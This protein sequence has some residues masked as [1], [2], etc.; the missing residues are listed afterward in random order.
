MR[1]KLFAVASLLI[2]ASMLLAA[3]AQPQT[4]PPP[5]AT[6][7]TIIQTQI[8]E[9]TVVVTVEGKTT[10]VTATPQPDLW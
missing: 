6:P 8:I 10:I 7:E 4:P 1:N 9:K 5:A 2:V 3:C